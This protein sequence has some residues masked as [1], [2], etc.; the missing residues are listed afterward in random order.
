MRNQSCSRDQV[1]SHTISNEEDY[2]LRLLLL[3]KRSN[4][5]IRNCRAAVIVR[6]G[7]DIVTWV[8]KSKST[9]GFRGHTNNGGRVG[10][11]REE[12]LIP[13][14]VPTL[15]S[16][17][18]SSKESCGT[19]RCAT[20]S[21]EGKSKARVGNASVCFGA[22]DWGMDLKTDVKILTRKKIRLILEKKNEYFK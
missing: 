3:R 14:K 2:I 20:W 19:L 12:I 6:E 15:Q 21:L 9:T 7:S 18:R 5:P 4:N 10:I 1:G 17:L 16:W 13:T 11:L 8:A 22:I